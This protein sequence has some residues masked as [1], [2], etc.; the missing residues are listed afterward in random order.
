M[1]LY[2]VCPPHCIFNIDNAASKERLLLT[3]PGDTKLTGYESPFKTFSSID[4]ILAGIKLLFQC[5]WLGNFINSRNNTCF[6][7]YDGNS[8]GINTSSSPDKWS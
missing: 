8:L 1:K 2:L 6:R 7:I 4:A 5:L 3:S